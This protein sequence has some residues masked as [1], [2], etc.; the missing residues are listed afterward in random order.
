MGIV[1]HGTALTQSETGRFPPSQDRL[2]RR[3]YALTNGEIRK[4]QLIDI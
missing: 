4:L 2:P 1:N 3:K